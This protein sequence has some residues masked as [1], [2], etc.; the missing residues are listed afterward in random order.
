MDNS[1]LIGYKYEHE[2]GPAVVVGPVS[3][4]ETYMAVDVDLG[5]G[6]E[7]LKTVCSVGLLRAAMLREL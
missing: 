6:I 3:W 2:S 7:P 4:G 1:D 5:E